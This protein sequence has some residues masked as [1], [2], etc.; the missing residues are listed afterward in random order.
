MSNV[1]QKK[2]KLKSQR[3]EKKSL[4]TNRYLHGARQIANANAIMLSLTTL[5]FLPLPLSPPP[6][7]PPESGGRGGRARC[8]LDQQGHRAPKSRRNQPPATSQPWPWSPL[9]VRRLRGRPG[10]S[11]PSHASTSFWRRE[12]P[13]HRAP[14]SQPA[15]H[16]LAPLARY[17][18]CG[19][20]AAGAPPYS[21]LRTCT[22][23]P[24]NAE[25]LQNTVKFIC[26]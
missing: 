14:P 11:S 24:L 20:R 8:F 22:W 25:G 23:R 13:S 9:D 17:A 26:I 5:P 16:S 3:V 1:L 18:L 10:E 4:K 6:F 15:P 19:L 12:P 21:V 2:K 7:L